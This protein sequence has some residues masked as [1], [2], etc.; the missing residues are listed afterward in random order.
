MIGA[1]DY[2]NDK[3]RIRRD[4]FEVY[5]KILTDKMTHYRVNG[6]INLSEFENQYNIMTK[7]GT[8]NEELRELMNELVI[9]IVH[10]F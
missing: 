7:F 6:Y 3:D 10:E 5:E 8:P 4:F 1:R 9:Q 2:V